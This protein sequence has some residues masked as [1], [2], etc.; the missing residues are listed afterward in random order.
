MLVPGN[1]IGARVS[2]VLPTK[3]SCW[4]SGSGCRSLPH[5]TQHSCFSAPVMPAHPSVLTCSGGN[6]PHTIPTA[7]VSG[8]FSVQVPLSGRSQDDATVGYFFQRQAGE[9]LS[10]YS[11]KHRWPTG[12]SIHVDHSEVFPNVQPEPLLLQFKPIASCLII[13]G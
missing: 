1:R 8:A 7:A 3:C 2:P 6:N 13:R 12:D 9:Q 11:S 4:G 10:G 5:C